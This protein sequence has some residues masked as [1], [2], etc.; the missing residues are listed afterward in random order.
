MGR[1]AHHVLTRKLAGLM[2]RFNQAS[3]RWHVQ[4]GTPLFALQE[5]A[6][7]ETEGMMRR[8]AHLAADNLAL[9][10]NG[11]G[12][13]GRTYGFPWYG[14]KLNL[15]KLRMSFRTH[16]YRCAQNRPEIFGGQRGN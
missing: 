15:G 8:N 14:W 9:H 6:G 10:A 12:N 5:L 13:H 16:S 2:V 3:R 7:W 11:L 4:G 1:R